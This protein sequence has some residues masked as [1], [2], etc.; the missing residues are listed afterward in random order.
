MCLEAPG[1]RVY[2]AMVKT[3][4]LLRIAAVGLALVASVAMMR[5]GGLAGG[6]DD[7]LAHPQAGTPGAGP[8]TGQTQ[9][10]SR[11]RGQ[12]FS[13]QPRQD[14]FPGLASERRLPMRTE[15]VAAAQITPMFPYRY[16]GW[17]FSGGVRSAYL[18]RGNETIAVVAGETLDKAW[19]VDALT[20]E[21]IEVFFIPDGQRFSIALTSA[22]TETTLPGAATVAAVPGQPNPATGTSQVAARP[23][24][25]ASAE[26]ASAGPVGVPAPGQF[27]PLLAGVIRGVSIAPAHN[28]GA[29]AGP[30]GSSEI[31]TG[32]LG[33]EAPASGSMPSGSAQRSGSMPGGPAPAGLMPS[34]PA[35]AARLGLDDD[36]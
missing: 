10:L 13:A 26:S 35:P 33:I 24:M 7:G 34:S 4:G 22:A 36:R 23:P 32:R 2:W 14:L 29:P 3:P 25:V 18:Q 12:G 1:A 8:E 27:G 16:A 9:E 31:P 20:A 17:V 28:A 5:L 6:G 30:A 11:S 15:P 19:R 21:S